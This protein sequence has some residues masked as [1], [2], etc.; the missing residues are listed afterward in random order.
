MVSKTWRKSE[1]MVLN[2]LFAGPLRKNII[3]KY[4]IRQPA[5]LKAVIKILHADLWWSLLTGLRPE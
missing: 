3:F 5:Y 1:R 4:N 2:F